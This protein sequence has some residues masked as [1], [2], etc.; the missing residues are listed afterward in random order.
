MR[1]FM[2]DGG[3]GPSFIL[4]RSVTSMFLLAYI[5][6]TEPQSSDTET[7]KDV[8][9]ITL[10]RNNSRI[11]WVML[12]GC[13]CGALRQSIL[14][15]AM[16]GSEA[17]TVGIISPT[18]PM[19]TAV[20]SHILRVEKLTKVTCFCLFL[21]T[22]GLT[23]ALN[24]WD[25]LGETTLATYFLLMMIPITKSLQVVFLR[26]ARDCFDSFSLVKNQIAISIVF[27]LPGAFLF[28]LFQSGGIYSSI[29][30]IS[31]LSCLFL[32]IR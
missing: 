8:R 27:C 30:T 17:S 10:I 3:A 25:S 14:P 23:L 22:I 6:Y 16:E 13:A 26:I 32:L 28:S 11:N 9:I 18:I 29:E 2:L 7:D 24:L 31:N 12:C 20:F 5:I 1:D 4:L 15:L 21:S 19:V